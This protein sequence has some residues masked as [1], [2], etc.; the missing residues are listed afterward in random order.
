MTDDELALYLTK[1]A[2]IYYDR[3]HLALAVPAQNDAIRELDEPKV[4]SVQAISAI[5]GCGEARV[6]KVLGGDT[7]RARGKLNPDHL[8]MIGYLLSQGRVNR[9]L[10]GTMLNNGTSLS[11]IA[12]LTNISQAT[13]YRWRNNELA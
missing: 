4:L 12:S 1:A 5:V 11:T 13:L 10:V 2:A 3:R 9:V 6:R 8:T 7:R